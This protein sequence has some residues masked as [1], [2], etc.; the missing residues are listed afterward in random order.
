MGTMELG[1]DFMKLNETNYFQWVGKALIKLGKFGV[2]DVICENNTTMTLAEGEAVDEIPVTETA[3]NKEKRNLSLK[4]TMVLLE[5]MV[6]TLQREYS[7]FK[8][9]KKLWHVLCLKFAS[10]T[11]EAQLRLHRDFI[12]VKFSTATDY[13]EK[14]KE[15]L[16]AMTLCNIRPIDAILI[17]EFLTRLPITFHSLVN[18]IY[19]MDPLTL[20]ICYARVKFAYAKN[21]SFYAQN[22]ANVVQSGTGGSSRTSRVTCYWCQQKGHY[23]DD[24]S[25]KRA[26]LE[27]TPRPVRVQTQLNTLPSNY[28]FIDSCASS[29]MCPHRSIFQTYQSITLNVVIANGTLLPVIGMGDITI[30][31]I[32]HGKTVLIKLYDVLHIPLLTDN[33]I[34]VNKLNM[35]GISVHFDSSVCKLVKD[36]TVLGVCNETDSVF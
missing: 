26:G 1:A 4:V 9:A 18:A 36:D 35:S 30:E 29:H 33:S 31:N 11:G 16:Y 7:G 19:S 14:F 8:S 20:D 17:E 32:I 6:D 13:I 24:C 12:A 27:K 15:I 34:S 28:W 5:G 25:A 22:R 2:R 21:P 10:P 3:I 23:M